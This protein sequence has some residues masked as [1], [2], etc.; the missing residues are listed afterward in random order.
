[1]SKTTPFQ[2]VKKLY[3]SKQALVDKVA[4]LL[5]PDEGESKEDF[6]ARLRTVANAKLL[7]LVAVGEKAAELGGREGIVA[8]IADL[9][10]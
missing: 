6:A 3:G 7:H 10:G 9:K 8:K 5:S 2:N 1:M 4:G